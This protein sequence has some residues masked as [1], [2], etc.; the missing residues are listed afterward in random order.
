MQARLRLISIPILL[1][2]LSAVAG[3]PGPAPASE[4]PFSFLPIWG[5]QARE[6]G[7]DL[8][9]PAGLGVSFMNIWQDYDIKSVEFEP[10][11]PPGSLPPIDSVEVSRA[12][13]NAYS[14][15]G[16]L[17]AWLFPFL[18]VYGVMGYTEGDTATTAAATLS[19]LGT[20]QFP[21]ALD[22]EGFTYGGGVTLVYGYK[23][24]FA[25]VDYN[26]TRT[27]L[28]IADSQIT[29][30]VVT[31]RIGWHGTAAGLKGSAW[32]GAMYQGVDQKFQGQLTVSVPGLGQIPV[33]YDVDEEATNPWNMVFGV[34][35]DISPHWQWMIEGGVIGREQ[36]LTS[37]LLRF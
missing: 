20:L 18:N 12:S 33:R 5:E 14:I 9:L 37:L 10:L 24:L 22:Y 32:L 29:A 2:S 11:V 25:M 36:I 4:S 6:R 16:R 17:D 21:F 15:D 19:G 28:D 13:G 30:H 31:P 27:D 3:E 26:Y 23:Q 1:F 34:Q 7:H 35:W 8:P